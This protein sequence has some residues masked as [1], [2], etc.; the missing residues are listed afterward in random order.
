MLARPKNKKHITFYPPGFASDNFRRTWDGVSGSNRVNAHPYWVVQPPSN[1]TVLVH[2]QH[3]CST[4]PPR[5]LKA[6]VGWKFASNK[7]RACGKM[8]KGSEKPL[9]VPFNIFNFYFIKGH[10]QVFINFNAK[11]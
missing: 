10:A 2:L 5:I 11:Y 9:A 1:P 7:G 8:P 3:F 6:K 4:H